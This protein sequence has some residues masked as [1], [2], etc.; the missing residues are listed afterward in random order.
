M[1]VAACLVCLAMLGVFS[2]LVKVPVIARVPVLLVDLAD[3][4]RPDEVVAVFPES[5]KESVRRGTT[6]QVPAAGRTGMVG[7]TVSGDGAVLTASQ[8][9]AVYPA[10]AEAAD[11]PARGMFAQSAGVSMSAGRG[12]GAG[13]GGGTVVLTAK[14]YVGERSLMQLVES[15]GRMAGS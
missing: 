1:I 9:V 14:G 13:A 2:V 5:A 12:V 8:L 10:L 6:V 11:L 15:A 7:V 3:G 4:A